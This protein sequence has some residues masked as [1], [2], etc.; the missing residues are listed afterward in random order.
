[1]PAQNFVWDFVPKKTPENA[2][3]SGMV[4][5]EKVELK[6]WPYWLAEISGRTGLSLL[7][8]DDYIGMSI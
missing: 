4:P 1:M 8:Y 5:F 3:I 7:I 6:V 2:N